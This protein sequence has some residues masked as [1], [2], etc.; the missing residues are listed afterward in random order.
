MGALSATDAMTG[1]AVLS[2]AR[3]AGGGAT[4]AEAVNTPSASAAPAAVIRVLIS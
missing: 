3:S 2:A 1:M 4:Q